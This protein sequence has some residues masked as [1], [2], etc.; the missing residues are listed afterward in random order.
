MQT[1]NPIALSQEVIKIGLPPLGMLALASD[2]VLVRILHKRYRSKAPAIENKA[3]S[4]KA[5]TNAV[6]SSIFWKMK[7]NITKF[8][9]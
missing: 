7:V 2:C 4:C 6:C 5:N 3:T 8:N 1:C 9:V